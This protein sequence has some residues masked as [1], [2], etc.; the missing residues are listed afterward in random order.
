MPTLVT[1]QLTI[2]IPSEI[3]L[4]QV[5][6][7]GDAFSGGTKCKPQATVDLDKSGAASVSVGT[8]AW[9][10]TSS[11]ADTDAL[12]MSGKPAW[13]RSL[14]PGAIP[15]ASKALERKPDN[16]EVKFTQ[17]PGATHAVQFIV[18]GAN[19]LLTPAPSIDAVITVGLRMAGAAIEYAVKGGHDGFPDY[20]LTI[21]GR[22]VYRWDCVAEKESPLALVAPMDRTVNIGW[23]RL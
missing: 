10:A 15:K 3:V 22:N 9:S 11:Y 23:Q 13:Y 4:Y 7:F 12:S 2:G 5:L 14:R 19:P 6:G 18:A 17:L 16:L 20:T 21:N 8:L 1:I